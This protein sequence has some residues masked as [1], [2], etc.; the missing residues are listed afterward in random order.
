VIK[1][2]REGERNKDWKRRR[3]RERK[4]EKKKGGEIKE[5]RRGR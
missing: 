5:R 3:G 1:M 2:G 4:A